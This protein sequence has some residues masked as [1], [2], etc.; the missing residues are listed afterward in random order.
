M[1]QPIRTDDGDFM[2]LEWDDERGYRRVRYSKKIDVSR[3]AAD[4]A[5]MH[6]KLKREQA[7]QAE[8][9]E[10]REERAG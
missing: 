1:S 9:S 6:E 5:W 2:I 8:Q 10:T 3:L 7:L 4:L